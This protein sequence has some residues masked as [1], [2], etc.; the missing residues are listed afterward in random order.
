MNGRTAPSALLLVLGVVTLR[1]VSTGTHLRYV[2]PGLGPYLVATGAVLVVLGTVGVFA[3]ALARHDGPRPSQVGWLLLVPVGLLA[4]VDPPALGSY[5]LQGRATVVTAPEQALDALPPPR[6]GAVELTL[7]DY[8][9]RSLF[10][11]QDLAGARLRLVGF[12]VP[13]TSAETAR[14][15]PG[16]YLTRIALSCCAADGRAVRVFVRTGD[17]PSPDTWWTVEGG[18]AAPGGAGQRAAGR[19]VQPDAVL[20]A[21]TVSATAAPD[22]PYTR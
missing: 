13:A 5:G 17:R 2:K 21:E 22:N 7:R 1:L 4:L 20:E 11:P 3:A 19:D 10:S 6:D 18:S 8:A 14:H 15:G 9:R 16:F 12:A